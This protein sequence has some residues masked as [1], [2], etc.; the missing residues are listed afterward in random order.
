ETVRDTSPQSIPKF[1]RRVYVR[2]SRYN[3]EEFEYLR[4]NRTEL[5]PIEGQPSLPQ[6][7]AVLLALFHITLIRNVFLRHLCF[8]VDCLSCEIGFLFRMLAD[9]VPLQP[10]SA[11]NFVRCLRSIDAA[12][13]LFDESAEQASLL[14]RTRSFV[15]F[16]WNRLKEVIYS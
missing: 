12:K 3:S 5:I 8:N 16:L 1:Y 6:A 10:A 14:S 13:K 2:P 9:R 7:S 15:Q 4:Y 11:S